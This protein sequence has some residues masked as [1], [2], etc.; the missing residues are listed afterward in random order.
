MSRPRVLVAGLGDTGLLTAIRLSKHADVVGISSKPGL[1]SGQELGLRLAR[2]REW[3]R[4][5]WVPFDRYHR[6]DSVRT[7]HGTLSRLDLATR[8]VHLT[9]PGGASATEPFDVLVIATGVTN[10]FWRRPDLQTRD[11]VAAALAADHDRLVAAATVIVLGGGAAAVS[12]ALNVATTWPDKRMDL[13]FP[14]EQA[15]SHHHRKVWRTLSARLERLG[16]GL[17]PRHRAVVPDG[18]GGDEITSGPVEWSTGQSA[19]KADA[20]LWTIGSVTPNTGWLPADLL[21]DKGFVVVDRYLRVPGAAG[22]YA[23]G[24]VAATDPLRTSAR[25]R[26]DGLLAHNIRAELNGG[27]PKSFTPAARRWG[28]VVG[29]QHNSLEVFTTSGRS[30]RIPAWSLLQP[31]IVRRGIYGGMRKPRIG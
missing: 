22:V 6:L 13:Y 7:V 20:V 16:V 2:P 14:G 28:S 31:F 1:V 17:H 21:D 11:Q 9:T 30:F 29:V 10:G 26:A 18:F 23:I 15:L 5:Y 12:S 3:A 19:S 24:D 25:S 27:T 8:C 4:D